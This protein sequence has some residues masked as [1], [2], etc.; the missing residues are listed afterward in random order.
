MRNIFSSDLNEPE[1]AAA[2]STGSCSV[3][4]WWSRSRS[5]SPGR[6]VVVR[7]VPLASFGHD[8]NGV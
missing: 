4:L 6:L 2:S 5:D 1:L 3:V 8:L 7:E